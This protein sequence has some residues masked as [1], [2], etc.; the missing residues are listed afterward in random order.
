MNFNRDAISGQEGLHRLEKIRKTDPDIVVIFITAYADMDKA[1]Q[2]IKAGAMDFIP[3][4]WNRLIYSISSDH[5]K[6]S[7]LMEQMIMNI[8]FGDLNIFFP[9]KAGQGQVSAFVAKSLIVTTVQYP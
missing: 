7:K 9:S 6:S 2:A 1:I 3:K 5:R 4:P 8:R